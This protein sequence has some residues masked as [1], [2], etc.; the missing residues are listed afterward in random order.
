MVAD[1]LEEFTRLI[2]LPAED[3]GDY[4]G[5]VF[6]YHREHPELLRLL[7]WEGLHYRDEPLPAEG[8]RA[9]YYRAKL[10]NMARRWGREP[11][12]EL[13]RRLLL[14]YAISAWPNAVP[15]VARLLIG[16]ALT[17]D[18]AVANM[19]AQIVAFARAA[20]TGFDMAEG[21]KP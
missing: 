5:Q 15:Q 13:G 21:R 14:L 18:E 12:P 19:R 10:E 16:E 7:L 6:D 3:P 8:P 17:G 9:E 2:D 11:S 20:V 4:A 1:A